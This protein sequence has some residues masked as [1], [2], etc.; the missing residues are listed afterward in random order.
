MRQF[1]LLFF[2]FLI[3]FSCSNEKNQEIQL[4]GNFMHSQSDSVTLKTNKLKQLQ[5]Q[6]DTLIKIKITKEGSFKQTLNIDPGYYLI[7]SNS[8]N[9]PIYLNAGYDLDIKSDSAKKKVVFA[10]KGKNENNYLIS[11]SEFED[12]ISAYN[13]YSYYSKFNEQQFLEFLNS[14]EKARMDLLNDYP[15]E[16]YFQFLESKSATI[17]KAHNLLTYPFVRKKVDTDYEKSDGY[18]DPIEQIEV[19]NEKLLNI[20]HFKLFLFLYVIDHVVNENETY[21]VGNSYLRYINS[22]S[23]PVTNE[24]IKEELLY[25]TAENTISKAEDLES[26]Y[27][28]FMNTSNNKAHKDEITEKYLEL[29]KLEKGKPIPYLELTDINGV[30]IKL[31][32]FKDSLIYIDIWA[33]WCKPC[34]EEIPSLIQLQKK[35]K[36]DKIKF[37]TIAI[38]SEK[39]KIAKLIESYDL[40]S[41]NIF[42][43][44]KEKKIKEIFQISGLPRYLLINKNGI[45]YDISAKRPSNK[46]LE[47]EINSLL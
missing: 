2:I 34:I 9:I 24:K 43:K 22:K 39:D 41:I 10:G 21:S 11:K 38:E 27:D 28:T 47:T 46:E 37:I 25:K 16:S 36:D 8:Q 14:V 26:F 23:F 30:N 13:H 5:Y 7:E 45:I 40:K 18:P 35:F 33:N 15:L 3:C 31:N 12:S 19:N 29:V 6:K 42:D 20:P 1:I 4:R 17:D 44:E 32:D